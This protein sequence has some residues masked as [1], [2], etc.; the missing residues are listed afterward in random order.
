MEIEFHSHVSINWPGRGLT[1][2]SMF[3]FK[4]V[5]GERIRGKASIIASRD[6]DYLEL[7]KQHEE[8]LQDGAIFDL[9]R[10]LE[11]VL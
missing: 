10:K 11:K 3:A 9:N 8:W 4:E 7:L 2:I 1:E 5:D 6:E